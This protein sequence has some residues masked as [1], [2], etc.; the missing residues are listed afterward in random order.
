ME[1]II[2]ADNFS[3]GVPELDEQHQQIILMIN[4]LVDY[5]HQEKDAKSIAFILDEMHS[6]IIEHFSTEERMLTK[7]KYKGLDEQ[8]DSHNKFISEFSHIC[9]EVGQDKEGA[10]K[11]LA[12][13]LNGWWSHHILEDD[14]QYRKHF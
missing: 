10:V 5:I 6:Y 7:I 11:H 9:A 12:T 2:W 14:M 1:K 3:V 13:Y 4:Q 8:K